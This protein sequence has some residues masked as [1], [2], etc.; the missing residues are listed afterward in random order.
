MAG[1]LYENPNDT[2]V[3][4][5]EIRSHQEAVQLSMRKTTI[6]HGFNTDSF[7]EFLKKRLRMLNN[8]FKR[9]AQLIMQLLQENDQIEK[10]SQR[11]NMR[12]RAA[13]SSLKSELKYVVTKLQTQNL[14]YDEAQAQNKID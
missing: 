3:L 6:S 12:M 8:S 11:S 7:L 9:Q 10:E 2:D 1:D 4:I 13:I 14:T 5:G